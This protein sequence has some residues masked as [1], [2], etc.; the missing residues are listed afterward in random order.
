MGAPFSCMACASAKSTPFL[1]QVPDYFLPTGIRRDYVRCEACGL[2]QQHP[3]PSDVGPFYA[4]YPVHAGKS[5]LHDAT[6]RIV[7][8][9]VYFDLAKLRPENVLLDY[10]CGDGWFLDEARSHVAAAYGFEPVSAQAE[11]V[12]KRVGVTVYSDEEKMSRELAGRVDVVT[13]HFV[14]EHL[15]DISGTITRLAALLKP[16][17][18]LRAVV[19]NLDNVEFRWF[20]GRWHGFDAPRHISFPNATHLKPMLVCAG[21]RV[22]EDRF[23]PFP[24]TLAASICIA[25]T[26][27]Y[28]PM[29]FM[30][31]MPLA[32]VWAH[33]YPR[34]TR[35][36]TCVKS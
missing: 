1:L 34:G 20:G 11:S 24:N 14:L 36:L 15:T 33:L 27:R 23:V 9:P 2:V 12:E 26:G 4:G 25:L 22:S 28:R 35:A 3:L 6:R 32:L 10:G 30:A 7:M 5:W 13:M 17:G 18:V 16:G 8:R 31:S 29:P 21:L 19:P